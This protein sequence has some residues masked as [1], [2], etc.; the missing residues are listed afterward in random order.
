[1]YHDLSALAA[2]IIIGVAPCVA[3]RAL[4][5]IPGIEGRLE[6]VYN[7]DIRII[8]DYAHTEAAFSALLSA[9]RDYSRGKIVVLFGCGGERYTGKR[10][11]MARIA[12]KYAS[13]IYVTSDNPR[14]EP[15]EKIIA[16][17]ISGFSNSCNYKA[18]PSREEAIR[19]AIL[20]AEPGETILLVGKGRERYN[21]DAEGYH[22]FDERDVVNLALK[23]RGSKNESK[24]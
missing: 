10:W 4:A 21:L 22:R 23:E 2:A 13:R 19:S 11:E 17:I 24:A 14:G 9:M 16:D 3:K 18:I 15:Q 5:P 7:D 12:E 6:T 20:E 1:M 8:I